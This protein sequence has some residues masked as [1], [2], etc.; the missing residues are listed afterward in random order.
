MTVA[1]GRCRWTAC[2]SSSASGSVCIV[3]PIMFAKKRA[4]LQ[5][6]A[7]EIRMWPQ[8]S[9]WLA[10]GT[11]AFRNGERSVAGSVWVNPG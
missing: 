6:I 11:R 2:W 4:T 5:W 8:L 3:R 9:C 10:I 1:S 7:P